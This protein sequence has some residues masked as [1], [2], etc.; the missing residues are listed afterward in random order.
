MELVTVCLVQ[1]RL[2]A[3]HDYEASGAVLNDLP[4]L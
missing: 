1:P 4:T 3:S 2:D